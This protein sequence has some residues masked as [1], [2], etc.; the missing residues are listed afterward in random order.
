MA[1][2]LHPVLGKVKESQ[3]IMHE[4]DEPDLVSDFSYPH[5]LAREDDTQVDFAPPDAHPSTLSHPQG[6]VMERIL[7]N[8]Q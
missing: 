6:A 1:H 8:L 4:A 3:V 2:R 7:G 5:A